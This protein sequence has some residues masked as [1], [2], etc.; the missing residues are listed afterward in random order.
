M[1]AERTTVDMLIHEGCLAWLG[2]LDRFGEDEVIA[3]NLFP[4]F[5]REF[6]ERKTCGV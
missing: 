4:Q 2:R 1:L 6:H 3:I 5:R